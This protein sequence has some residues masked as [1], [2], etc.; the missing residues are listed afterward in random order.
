MTSTASTSS[1]PTPARSSIPNKG[2]IPYLDI[3]AILDVADRMKADAVHA[4]IWLPFR[5]AGVRPQGR[6]GGH[7][8]DRS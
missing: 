5:E 1:S 8:L 2:I 6:G 3:E 7:D 4:W